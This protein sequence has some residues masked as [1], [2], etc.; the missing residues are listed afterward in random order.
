M[1]R[2][3]SY[4]A[5][6]KIAHKLILS[7][8]VFALPIAVLLYFAVAGF[9]EGIRATEREIAG[10]RA[11][12][13][14]PMLLSDLRRLQLW[15]YLANEG[16]RVTDTGLE[17]A[18]K[19]VDAAV[20]ALGKIPDAP[21]KE[22]AERVAGL[23]KQFRDPNRRMTV[24]ERAMTYRLM[25][26]TANQLIPLA[27]DHYALVL[28]SELDTYYLMELSGTLLQQS[29][30]A[31]AQARLIVL[32][33]GVEKEGIS[34]RDLAVLQTQSE[35]LSETL[36]PRMR[37]AIETAVKEDARFH[38][39]SFT[40]QK[41]IPPLCDRYLN[42]LNDLATQLSVFS[43]MSD[44][45]M[46][47]DKVGRTAA[48]AE[49]TGVALWTATIP[50]L[51]RLLEKRASDNRRSRAGAL[52]LCLFSVA[53]A[54]G[55]VVVVSRN[56]TQPLEKVVDLTTTIAAGRVKEA[57]NRLKSDEFKEML[58]AKAAGGQVR[59]ETFGLIRSV[60]TMTGNLNAL[61]A[62]VIVACDQVAGGANLT[63]ATVREIEAAVAE[64]AASTN[65][66][67]ATSKQIHST[68]RQLADTMQSVTVMA[69]D[70]AR[71]ANSGVDSLSGI[72]TA[73]EALVE[74]SQS[75]TQSFGAI[76]EK[77]GNIDKVITSIT[78]IANRT[79]LLSLNAAIEAE[80]AGEQ[81][82][83]FSVVALEVRRL[84]DQTAVA[85]LDIERQ[86]REMQQAV[87]DGMA[88]VASYTKRTEASSAAVAELS[89]GLGRVIEGTTRL[90]PEFESVNAG[91]QTQSQGAGQI[92]DSMVHLRDAAGQT[93]TSLAE[94]RRVAEDLH[95]AVGELQA[96][97]GRFSTAS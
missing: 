74:T 31:A 69:A 21:I 60:Y 86:I 50:E 40:L 63:T 29:Q 22:A 90:G 80:K 93:R 27:L 11:L 19:R 70:A 51:R 32:R 49:A 43:Q 3:N 97:V 73:I 13:P 83:G 48:N 33:S 37:K 65:Q 58:A 78:K 44:T 52:L 8:A 53:L 55:V 16:V 36:I 30:A 62:K 59:D 17:D 34:Q 92:A 95:K 5:R 96:E 68:A 72:R 24:R 88:G 66:V 12:E 42:A 57:L 54:A 56:V 23:W 61:L 79:N 64:Q 71:T 28:D 4:L 89:D 39:Q 9:N 25:I 2:I 94:F 38:G 81:A 6:L 7:S 47:T 18:A 77:T 84:A 85:A 20:E 82:G 1:N 15:S 76:Q 91:M 35:M 67:S 14:C 75:M 46:T 87:R 10:T 45:N 26:E 41:V